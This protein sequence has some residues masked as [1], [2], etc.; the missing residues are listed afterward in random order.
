MLPLDWSQTLQK[1]Q[2][3]YQSEHQSDN[4]GGDWRV[5]PWGK[6]F[7]DP[8]NLFLCDDTTTPFGRK[9]CQCDRKSS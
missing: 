7:G 8:L 1:L 9:Y 6:P 3:R 2:V 5:R 4:L